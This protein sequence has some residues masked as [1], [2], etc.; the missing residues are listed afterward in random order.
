MTLKLMII[1]YINFCTN[2]YMHN[3]LNYPIIVVFKFII[4]N[5]TQTP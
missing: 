1:E 2:N 5:Q 3:N 4:Q